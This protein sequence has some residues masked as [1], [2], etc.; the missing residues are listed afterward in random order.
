LKSEKFESAINYFFR[1]TMFCVQAIPVDNGA[2]YMNLLL[3]YHFLA[4]SIEF[5]LF[6]IRSTKNIAGGLTFSSQNRFIFLKRFQIGEDETEGF[7][8]ERRFLENG[9]ASRRGPFTHI[10]IQGRIT[11]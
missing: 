8:L 4:V 9:R 6:Q 2:E 10:Q 7:I 5:C 3:F 1:P 11:G